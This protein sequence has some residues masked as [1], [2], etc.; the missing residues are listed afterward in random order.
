M[1]GC[2]YTRVAIKP[3]LV[4]VIRYCCHM[5]DL[6][7]CEL[8]LSRRACA[9]KRKTLLQGSMLIACNTCGGCVSADSIVYSQLFE[10]VTLLMM[11]QD[12]TIDLSADEPQFNKV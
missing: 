10:T 2:S 4:S 9:W 6:V 8:G 7:A 11:Y 3:N 12:F 1:Q 5:S